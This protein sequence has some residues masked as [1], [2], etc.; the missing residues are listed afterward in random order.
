MKA[1]RHILVCALV[2]VTFTTIYSLRYESVHATNVTY[3]RSNQLEVVQSLRKPLV[4][5]ELMRKA[6]AFAAQDPTVRYVVAYDY[7]QLAANQLHHAAMIAEM[8]PH[9]VLEA[10]TKF[11]RALSRFIES[12]TLLMKDAAPLVPPI[13]NDLHYAE[14]KDKDHF[15]NRDGRMMLYGGHL[16]ESYQTEQ[17]RTKEMLLYYL[18]L[19]KHEVSALTEAHDA[20]L[21]KMPRTVPRDVLEHSKVTQ[22]MQGDGIVFL[23]GGRYNQLV[24]VSIK[25]LRDAGSKL[26]IEVVIK[27]W[28]PLD[29]RFCEDVLP[30]LE[31]RCKVI[32][33]YLVPSVAASVQ[34]FQLKNLAL[35][36]LSFQRVLYMDADNIVTRNPDLLF[37]N[38]PFAST[39]FVLWPDLW[40]RSTSPSFYDIVGIPVDNTKRVRN[41]Y[42][43]GDPRGEGDNPS[44]HDCEGAIPEASSETGQ[45]LIDKKKHFATLVLA[46]YYNYYGFDYYYPLLSQGAAG[47]GD[48]ETFIAAA[49]KLGLPYYQVQEFNREFGPIKPS[50]QHELFGMGQ[51][52][53]ILDYIQSEKGESRFLGDSS[54]AL[55]D[56]PT[57]GTSDTDAVTNNYHFHLYEAS[58]LMFLH[59][60]WPKLY[61]GELLLHNGIGRGPM[62][63]DK[64]RRLYG[65]E[66]KAEA[67]FDFELTIAEAMDWC[68]CDIQVDLHDVPAI[69]LPDRKAACSLL[70]EHIDFLRKD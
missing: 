40:R 43:K 50:K 13:N 25:L 68:Y 65:P 22:Y 30:S 49:H 27:D 52:D 4:Y 16:R 47:E 48:K 10:T 54:F 37:V 63:G 60:N 69:G 23:A 41:S 24:L 66:L 3:H 5:N 31:A 62:D 59:A 2:L 55:K 18:R 45:I 56:A 70:Q 64:R 46:M 51:Y 8:P 21:N 33:H 57:C 7:Q 61:F 29:A 53:P 42:F 14:A 36:V 11:N 15:A 17:V 38:E 58:S 12:L 32:D 67:G 35:L 28:N 20:F 34:S 39:G 44:L 6:P 19:L 26:P 1:R 9:K